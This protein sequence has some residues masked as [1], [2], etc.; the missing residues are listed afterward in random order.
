[1]AEKKGWLSRLVGRKGEEPPPEAE[2][3][4]SEAE[5]EREPSRADATSQAR[6][7]EEIRAAE[8]DVATE[9]EVGDVILDL[10]EVEDVHT[11]G[12]MGLVYRVR[13]LD[14]GISLAAKSPR[15]HFFRT[16]TQKRNFIRECETWIDLGLHPHIVSCYYV[17]SLGD[18]P[19]VFAEYVEGGSL[20]EWVKDER[21]YE[22]GPEKALERIIDI[23]IQCAW[24]LA[25]SHEQGL[26]HRDVKPAN[27][28]MTSDGVA[29]VTDFGLAKAQESG[30]RSS[31]V[32]KSSGGLTRAYCSPEQAQKGFMDHRTDIWSWGLSV[33]EMFTGGLIWLVGQAAPETLEEY[34]KSDEGEP[35]VPRMPDPLAALLRDCFHIDPTSR[36]ESLDALSK[37][38]AGV[39][40]EV[41]GEE[42][43]RRRPRAADHRAEG[44]NNRAVSFLDLGRRKDAE[45]AFG[46]ALQSDPLHPEATYNQGLVQWRTGRMT[47][48]ALVK[49]LEEVRRSHREQWQTGYYLGLVHMERGDAGAAVNVLE[50]AV[51][52]SAASEEVHRALTAAKGGLGHWGR[53]LRTIEGPG[54]PVSAL[55]VEPQGRFV[56]AAIEESLFLYDLRSGERRFRLEGHTG[57]VKSLSMSPDG[58]NAVSGSADR[59]LRLWGLAAG[60]CVRTLQGHRGEVSAVALLPDSRHVLSGSD[61]RT[62]RLW[63]ASSGRCLRTI[64]GHTDE[65]LA[66]AVSPDGRSA[67]S[68][69]ADRTLRYWDLTSGKCR[70]VIKGHSDWVNSVAISRSGIHALSGSHDGTFGWWD[71]SES[72]CLRIIEGHTGSVIS[73]CLSPDGRRAL[74]GSYDET[75]RIWDLASGRC[76]RTFE[77]HRGWVQGALL[78][79]GLEAVSCGRDGTIRLWDLHGAGQNV[80]RF[81]VAVPSSGAE[82]VEVDAEL[83]R[84]VKKARSALDEGQAAEALK[85]VDE[86]RKLSGCER[87]ADLLALWR[88]AGARGRK[89]GLR[90]GW[91]SRHLSGHRGDVCCVSISPDGRRVLS[92][93]LDRTIRL[94]DPASE[95]CVTTLEGHAEE[96]SSVCFGPDGRRVLSGSTDSMLR[97][98]DLDS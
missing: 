22:G 4:S 74:T 2:E 29:K 91:C 15:P 63:D 49:R 75:L 86:A 66:V 73:V 48:S 92:S 39:Y 19:R 88:E 31:N 24:G 37:R 21:L 98:W 56:L 58:K 51:E 7:Q 60:E 42:Y 34:L 84:R 44:L 9:W 78:P 50:Q 80:G 25:H 12:G 8:A 43:P 59:T 64:E 6:Q 93:G 89:V 14:W 13:H 47:D 3:A 62:L 85:V 16:E 35:G 68:G 94:W 76:R 38:L 77:G 30:E 23:S 81:T 53:C 57:T 72:K 95:Q 36:P 40:R 70:K 83:R 20:S 79:P 11:G 41:I 26:I 97:Y 90:A 61:D 69:G 52:H 87:S 67:L 10:Y 71:L 46:Q 82:V 5:E 45:E 1:M 28:L 96:V 18:I 55:D 33:L 17:R 65:I 54:G 27:V 32:L